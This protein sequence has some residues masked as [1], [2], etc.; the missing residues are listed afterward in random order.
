MSSAEEAVTEGPPRR[1]NSGEDQRSEGV[2]SKRSEVRDQR[3][4][5]GSQRSGIRCKTDA[6]LWRRRRWRR[7][8]ENLH[9][10]LQNL[11]DGRLVYVQSRE[12]SFFSTAASFFASWG[13]AESASRILRNARTTKTLT[14]AL[15]RRSVASPCDQCSPSNGVPARCIH[16]H[17]MRAVEDIRGHDCT[18]FGEGV[19]QCP[20]PSTSFL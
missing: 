14:R 19:R 6:G 9:Y 13:L 12:V 5:E 4:A 15:P 10:L 8:I 11:H 17:S 16:L 3:T 18:V 2:C 7:R 1:I 20:A